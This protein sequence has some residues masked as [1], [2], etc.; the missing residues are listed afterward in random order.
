M[1]APSPPFVFF[2]VFLPFDQ[3]ACSCVVPVLSSASVALRAACALSLPQRGCNR[4][5]CLDA[6]AEPQHAASLHSHACPFCITAPSLL[7]LRAGAT[8]TTKFNTRKGYNTLRLPFNSFRSV[9]PEDPPLRPGGL[10][11]ASGYVYLN[12]E[13]FMIEQGSGLLRDQKPARRTRGCAQAAWRTDL[14]ARA[15]PNARPHAQRP[16]GAAQCRRPRTCLDPPAP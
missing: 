15:S 12:E 1:S 10:V 8:Y 16:V 13:V 3:H 4:P 11:V 5:P 9:N 7:L 14:I 2:L 6:C